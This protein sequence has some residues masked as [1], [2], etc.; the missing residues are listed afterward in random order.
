MRKGFVGFGEERGA[1]RIWGEAPWIGACG[2]EGGGGVR[3]GLELR[4][5]LKLMGVG[6]WRGAWS[7]GEVRDVG[8]WRGDGSE[9][10]RIGGTHR[11]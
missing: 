2:A 7:G 8:V 3:G 1:S 5:G 10:K 6:V 9:N 4:G 11:I